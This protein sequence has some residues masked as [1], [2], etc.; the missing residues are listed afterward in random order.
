MCKSQSVVSPFESNTLVCYQG[1]GYDGCIRE[2]NFAYID[3]ESEFHSILATG[4]MGCKTPEE[5]SEKW[6]GYQEKLVQWRKARDLDLH[7]RRPDDFDLYDL[8][9]PDEVTRAADELPISRLL[10]LARWFREAEIDVMFQPMCGECGQRFDAVQ[11]T[12]EEPSG[13]GGIVL[14]PGKIVCQG[15]KGRYT[16]AYCGE[17]AGEGNMATDVVPD[18][19]TGYCKWCRERHA[20]VNP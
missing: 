3:A 6:E 11:G 15:C 8:H 20:E 7:G 16:C 19:D 17:Y 18:D 13:V 5:L 14:E 10:G 12:G 4:S 9:D 2:L 1:G